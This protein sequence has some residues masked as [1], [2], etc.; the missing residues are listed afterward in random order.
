MSA[1]LEYVELD[2]AEK[3]GNS[4]PLHA[5]VS[6]LGDLCHYF[7]DPPDLSVPRQ[8]FGDGGVWGLAFWSLG[9]DVV[10]ISYMS[11]F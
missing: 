8:H 7:I 5:V 11:I 2:S 6:L 3:N 9:G 10:P 4:K 1:L